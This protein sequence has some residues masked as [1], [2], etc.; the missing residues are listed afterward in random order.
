MSEKKSFWSNF[1]GKKKAGSC[2]SVRIEEVP[3]EEVPVKDEGK[4][5]CC[6]AENK[7]AAEKTKA[8]R[9]IPKT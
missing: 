6:G 3:E 1:F 9:P 7:E 5:A 4:Q 2:C 8:D